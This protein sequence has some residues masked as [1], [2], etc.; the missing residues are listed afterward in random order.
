LT[1]AAVLMLVGVGAAA[2]GGSSAGGLSGKS[3]SQVLAL[4]EAAVKTANE[5]HF[6]DKTTSGK[7]TLV[8]SG[9]ISGQTGEEVLSGPAGTLQ[10]RLIG[11][12]AYL[13]GSAKSI[14]APLGLSA[15]QGA[16]YANKWIRLDASDG[17]FTAVVESIQPGAELKPY[18]ALTGLELGKVST[19]SK[20]QVLQVGGNAPSSGSATGVAELYVSTAAPY[21]PY[22]GSLYGT[23]SDGSTKEVVD[24]SDWGKKL[25]ISVP[26]PIV[27][28]SSISAQG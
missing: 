17:P 12:Y 21:V 25:N 16:K 10:V 24:F 1:A 3:A 6:V 2:C 22:G 5:F 18:I 13:M 7:T 20:H 4:A 28:F 27:A 26:T 19:L 15:T 8:L 11:K 14:D 23:G 9:E